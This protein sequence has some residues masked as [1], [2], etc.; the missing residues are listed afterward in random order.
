MDPCR[1]KANLALDCCLSRTFI[2]QYVSKNGGSL[3]YFSRATVVA[4]ALKV[5]LADSKFLPVA[6][7]EAV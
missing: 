7:R 6:L 1:N 5:D 4:R 2:P 3:V